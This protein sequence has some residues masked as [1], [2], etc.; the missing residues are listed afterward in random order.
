M[1]TTETEKRVDELEDKLKERDRTI[2]EIRQDA[3]KA[4]TTIAKQREQVQDVND[5]ID[6]WIEAFDMELDDAGVWRW[7]GWI[8]S[9]EAVWEKY[10]A[11]LR[12]WNKFVGRYNAVVSAQP[13]GR[14][15]AATEAQQREVI[16]LRKAGTSLRAIASATGLGLGTVRTIIGHADDG[17][18]LGAPERAAPAR[19]EPR[20]H[21]VLPRP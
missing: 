8:K 5:L 17:S 11:L 15:L 10:H 16:K 13:V 4:Q 6:S 12:D 18:R 20:R 1:D 9:H 14:P 2:L 19:A 21:G 7:A 3:E